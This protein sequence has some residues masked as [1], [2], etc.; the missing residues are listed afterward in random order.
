MSMSWGGNGI[1]EFGSAFWHNE[2]NYP[3]FYLTRPDSLTFRIL[4]ERLSGTGISFDPSFLSVN[5]IIT[6]DS[7]FHK[8][9]VVLI[10]VESLSEI[11]R[12]HV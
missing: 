9:N 6:S 3:D 10:S 5:R 1:F 11:G 12:A 4:R 7:P 8:W 2:I